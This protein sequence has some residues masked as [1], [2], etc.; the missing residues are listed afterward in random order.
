MKMISEYSNIFEDNER[1]RKLFTVPIELAHFT[2]GVFETL[3]H[4]LLWTLRDLLLEYEVS[5]AEQD[6]S[7][8]LFVNLMPISMRGP[9]LDYKQS[10]ES[11]CELCSPRSVLSFVDVNKDESVVERIRKRISFGKCFRLIKTIPAFF[12]LAKRH[13]LT[14]VEVMYSLPDW[15]NIMDTIRILQ[16]IPLEKYELV[17]LF[18]DAEARQNF[19]AQVADI[20]CCDTATLQ[21]G[22]FC[23]PLNSATNAEEDG[24]ELRGVVSDYFL[25]WNGLTKS[26]AIDMGIDSNRV[27][28][29][30]NPKFLNT[31][32]SKITRDRNKTFGV[33]LGNLAFDIDNQ[34][35]IRVA[36]E[37]AKNYGYKFYL[38]YHPV[39]P[40]SHY[41]SIVDKNLCAGIVDKGIKLE[42]YS[43][44]VDFTIVGQSS[45]FIELIY[46]NHPTFHL[47][48][49]DV[50][51]KFEILR[52]ISFSDADELK[53]K[54]DE[55]LEISQEMMDYIVGPS[56]TTDI[57]EQY[58]NFFKNYVDSDSTNNEVGK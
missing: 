32:H 21:H 8:V 39:V 27:L 40:T 4:F 35:L 47:H 51:D 42:E 49:D 11:I 52:M 50:L 16:N 29:T 30:G 36:T 37:F 46:M 33:I 7:T 45:M 56:D 53:T 12:R 38:K 22:M 58:M 3:K 24:V 2:T 19:I 55:N 15:I 57:K 6:K 10:F 54:I 48:S 25:A 26:Y 18:C 43:Q 14:S 5:Y 34:N 13:G 20:S 23:S 17:V 9:R 1:F 31:S 44:M 28:V 41:D